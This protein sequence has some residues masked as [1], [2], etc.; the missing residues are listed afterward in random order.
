MNTG[1]VPQVRCLLGAGGFPSPLPSSPIS[2]PVSTGVAESEEGEVAVTLVPREVEELKVAVG[3]RGEGQVELDVAVPVYAGL[4]VL[5]LP[6]HPEAAEGQAP[7]RRGRR[8]DPSMFPAAVHCP[9]GSGSWGTIVYRSR[10]S[11]LAG[12]PGGGYSVRGPP[13]SR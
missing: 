10:V 11:S 1:L 12:P 8:G 7:L 9:R 13:S 6:V 5:V 4:R 3:L 2:C